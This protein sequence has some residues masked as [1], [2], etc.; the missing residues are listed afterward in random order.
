M[1]SLIL[2]GSAPIIVSHALA[3][4]HSKFF[5]TDDNNL[6][7]NREIIRLGRNLKQQDKRETDLKIQDGFTR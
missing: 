3:D 6:L 7:G 1:I 4:R 5:F 2:A